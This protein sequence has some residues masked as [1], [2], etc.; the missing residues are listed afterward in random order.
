[1]YKMD[2][3]R[4][5]YQNFQKERVNR[6]PYL[7]FPWCRWYYHMLRRLTAYKAKSLERATEF[8][9]QWPISENLKYYQK[10]EN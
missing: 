5:K 4:Y 9:D 10:E 3:K 1:M 2:K 6:K 7:N 8:F